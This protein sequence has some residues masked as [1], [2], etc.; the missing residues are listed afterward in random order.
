ML[1]RARY[2]Y[3]ILISCFILTF[4]SQASATCSL[5]STAQTVHICAPADGS[6]VAAP[7]SISASATPASGKMIKYMQVFVDGIKEYEVIN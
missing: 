4:Y 5:N 7:V 6:S 2:C 3:V 1:N